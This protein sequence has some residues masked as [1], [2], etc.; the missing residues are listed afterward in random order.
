MIRTHSGDATMT[1]KKIWVQPTIKTILI[2]S[3]RNGGTHLG[4]GPG[5]KS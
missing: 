3:A 4:D 1:T 2:G 5:T